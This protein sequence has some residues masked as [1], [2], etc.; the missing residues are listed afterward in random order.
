MLADK[1]YSF[2]VLVTSDVRIRA[3]LHLR[4]RVIT[5][6]PP[7]TLLLMILGFSRGSVEQA[8]LVASTNVDNVMGLHSCKQP[9]LLN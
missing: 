8:G 6:C 9:Q 5:L 3:Y 7:V 1:L 4:D 2:V